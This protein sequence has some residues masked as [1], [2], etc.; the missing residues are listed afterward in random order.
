MPTFSQ[1]CILDAFLYWFG[2]FML[3]AALTRF[4]Q[5]KTGKGSAWHLRLRLPR[6][7]C[8]VIMSL[9]A[10]VIILLSM[11]GTPVP[12]RARTFFPVPFFAV[13]LY[14]FTT[15]FRLLKDF[16]WNGK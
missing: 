11:S 16:R 4:A 12:E 14:Y 9:A 10:I 7:I 15:F 3:L 6:F 2:T 8:L 1:V 13:S 5:R